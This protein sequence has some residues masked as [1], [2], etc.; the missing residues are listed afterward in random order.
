MVGSSGGHVTPG[1]SGNGSA[2]GN[3]LFGGPSLFGGLSQ[4]C[5]SGQD[6]GMATSITYSSSAAGTGPFDDRLCQPHSHQQNH[7]QQQQQAIPH[8]QL[9]TPFPQS[10]DM[11]LTFETLTKSSDMQPFN[12]LGGAGPQHPHHSHQQGLPHLQVSFNFHIQ[13][14][15]L[16]P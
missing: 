9:M 4:A 10:S 2:G 7:P 12:P 5:T 14:P 6:S 8:Q 13:S 15:P 16:P 1:S 3:W 11:G